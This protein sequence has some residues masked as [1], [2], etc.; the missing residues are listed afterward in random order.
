MKVIITG[1]TGMVGKGVLLESLNNSKITE[2]LL[3]NRNPIDIQNPKI[4]EII[5]KDFMDVSSIQDQLKGYDACF[6]CLGVSAFRMSEEQYTKLT[7]DLTLGFANTLVAI[8]P[9]MTFCYVSGQGTDS[10]EKGSSMWARVKGKTENDLLKL[11]FDHTFMYRP[12]GI[13]PPKGVKSKTPLYNVFLPLVNILY[14][15]FKAL[16]PNSI[17]TSEEIG[18]SMINVSKNGSSY[19]HLTAKEINQTATQN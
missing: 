10:S 12:G 2:V 18:R 5:H 7:Y 11:G 14:P 9:N 19:T 17:T 8:N 1:A 13:K 4:K 16:S 15:V 6:F 3:I